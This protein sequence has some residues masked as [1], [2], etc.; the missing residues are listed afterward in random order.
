[1]EQELLPATAAAIPHQQVVMLQNQSDLNEPILTTAVTTT[2][3]QP[4]QVGQ[5]EALPLSTSQNQKSLI[6]KKCVMDNKKKLAVV[7]VQD[8]K[9]LKMFEEVYGVFC[10]SDDGKFLV[11]SDIDSILLF[12]MQDGS[13]KT[14]KYAKMGRLSPDEKYLELRYCDCGSKQCC[15]NVIVVNTLTG[16]AEVGI[17]L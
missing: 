9:V 12:N 5:L 7:R 8:G 16:Y 6:L 17:M 2:L 3:H 11:I 14:F 15:G 1:M 10:F 4:M 13:I